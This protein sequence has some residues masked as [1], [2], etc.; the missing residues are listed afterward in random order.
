VNT[1]LLKAPLPHHPEILPW[2]TQ[3]P[4]PTSWS[5]WVH[6][7]LLNTFKPMHA[8]SHERVWGAAPTSLAWLQD[9]LWGLVERT[10]FLGQ[11]MSN[12]T[13]K[14]RGLP[15]FRGEVPANA[16]IHSDQEERLHVKAALTKVFKQ[17]EPYFPTTDPSGPPQWNWQLAVAA[18][19]SM[20]AAAFSDGTI[21][22]LD[23]YVKRLISYFDQ[24]RSNNFQEKVQ[25]P[26][27][28]TYEIDCR[29]I[30][31]E[32]LLVSWMSHEAIH[33]GAHDNMFRL[34]ESL[35]AMTLVVVFEAIAVGAIVQ[36]LA[37]LFAVA[38]G[39]TAFAMLGQIAAASVL[40]LGAAI[41]LYQAWTSRAREERADDKGLLLT[42]AAGY[43]PLG[44]VLVLKARQEVDS[45][46]FLPLWT[47]ALR[48]YSDH[49]IT[50]ARMAAALNRILTEDAY[51]DFRSSVR[52]IEPDTKA[53]LA[54]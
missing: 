26:D 23:G 52:K 39:T 41:W 34:R 45:D 11:Q 31:I 16:L 22:V 9:R 36:G 17:L 35:L 14:T 19:P 50:G 7:Q 28:T 25:L 4:K 32:D 13:V 27:G 15:I 33:V 10:L 53:T 12:A 42:T 30:A 1:G 6:E 40:L 37:S 48:L 49:P 43:N 54:S 44:T 47:W 8:V 5:G 21:L 2:M 3:E 51:K 38:T 46:P 29:D 18:N 20:N 24:L